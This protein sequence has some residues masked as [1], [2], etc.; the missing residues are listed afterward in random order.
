MRAGRHSLLGGLVLFFYFK[1]LS[2]KNLEHAAHERTG[3]II[4]L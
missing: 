1:S 2:P 3:F 4:V